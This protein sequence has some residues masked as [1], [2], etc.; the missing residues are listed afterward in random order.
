MALET[1]TYINTLDAT[2]PTATDP[3]NQGDDHLRLIK[4]AVKATFPN[5]A[6]AVTPTHAELNHV[7]GVTSA[8]QTQLNAKGDVTLTGAQTLTNK[9]L[10]SPTLTGTPT[11]PTATGGTN[12]T[13]V[14][15]TAFVQA[16]VSAG[17]SMVYPG[18]GLAVSTG[19]A[20]GASKT[21]PAG[22][23]VGDTDT[24]TLSNKTLTTPNIGTPSAGN[25]SNCTVDGTNAI[26]YKNIPQNAQSANYTLVLSDAGKHIYHPGTDNAPRVFTIPAN[27]S[28]AFPIGSVITFINDNSSYSVLININTD[29]LIM[30]P[31]GSTGARTLAP[32]GMA[33]AIKIT[34]TD[35]YISGTGLT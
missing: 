34:A 24:Q 10:T 23:L 9:S 8:I 29:T 25:L 32:Y 20:W 27:A 28:V 4:S 13:Q 6:G 3:K 1:A 7:A 31:A 18:A 35:W 12:T 5:V 19:S 14:A 33:T 26:G 21:A 15:T 16:A 11:A 22:A 17:G 2:N 30:S